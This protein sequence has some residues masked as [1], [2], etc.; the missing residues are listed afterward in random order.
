MTFR[1]C[2]SLTRSALP[3]R[4]GVSPPEASRAAPAIRY[5]HRRRGPRVRARRPQSR[6]ATP[7]RGPEVKS[8]A[9]GGGVVAE[10]REHRPLI[11]GAQ[12]EKA[13]PGEDAVEA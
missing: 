8:A 6:L 9:P 7:E 2:L 11:A 3:Q 10:D 4:L 12:V 13:V 1:T 5:A